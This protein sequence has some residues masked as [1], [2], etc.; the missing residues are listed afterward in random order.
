MNRLD[1][2]KRTLKITTIG[3]LSALAII[4]SAVEMMIPPLPMM[5]P[6]AKPGFSNIVTMYASFSIGIPSA[7]FI[8]LI[9]SC[10]VGVTRGATA[11]LMSLSGG[12]LSTLVMGCM[13]KLKRNPFGLIGIGIAGALTH[14]LAQLM[15]AFLVTSGAVIYYL[16]FLIIY[17]I[18]T[19]SVTG[20]ILKITLPALNK[21]NLCN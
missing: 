4:I 9:K 18:I 13:F 7:L 16:P 8:A 15:I 19:G 20:I 12:L 21:M 3:M 10:F 1:V 6:G 17:A 5:P 2:K 11:F 14:N